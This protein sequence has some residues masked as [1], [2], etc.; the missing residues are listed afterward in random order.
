MPGKLYYFDLGGRAEG[1]RALLGHANFQY[2]DARQ[3]KEEF[4]QKKAEG[5][6]PLGSMPVWEED[7][8]KMCQSSAVL[9]M[10]GIRLGYYSEDPMTCWAIDSIVDFV[11]DLQPKYVGYV[12]AGL[13]GGCSDDASAW[14]ADYWD[15]VIPVIEKRLAGHGKPFI[16]GT[17][18]PTIADFKAFQTCI[19]A[20]GEHNPACIVPQGVQDQLKAKWAASPHYNRWVSA[21]RSEL[22][23][24]LANVRPARPL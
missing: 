17:S 16:G 14:F 7:G 22:S 24:Y 5:F 21:M 11:E 9:R 8:F 1:I 23:S 15:K 18:R 6:W 4:G 13:E 10:L 2:E 20:V 3:T 19:S 12:F